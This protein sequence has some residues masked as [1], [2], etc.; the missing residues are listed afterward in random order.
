MERIFYDYIREDLNAAFGTSNHRGTMHFHLH[1]E[2]NCVTKGKLSV[3]NNGTTIYCEYPC[4]LIHAPCSFHCVISDFDMPYERYKFHFNDT[5][6]EKYN[7]GILSPDGIFSESFS[8]IPMTG[9]IG[10]AILPYLSLFDHHRK[11]SEVNN[12]FFAYLLDIITLFYDRRLPLDTTDTQPGKISY[13]GKVLEYISDN[14]CE[15]FTVEDLSKQFYVSKTKLNNDFKEIIGKTIKQHIIDVRIS[16]AMKM[17]THGKS[18]ITTA[19]DCGFADESNF[20]R[21]FRE[22]V[23]SSPKKFI[24]NTD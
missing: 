2:I 12:R 8:V 16:N 19:H 20:I 18:V 5:Y 21:T 1:Y 11:N 6:L 24:K 7:P 23:G 14:F 4:I 10:E 9:E 22:R 17:L 15:D 13:I 3:I